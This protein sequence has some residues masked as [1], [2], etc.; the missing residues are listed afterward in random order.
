[1]IYL[2]VSKK[3]KCSILNTQESCHRRI[4]TRKARTPWVMILRLLKTIITF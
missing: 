3:Y 1:M 2:T 4:G